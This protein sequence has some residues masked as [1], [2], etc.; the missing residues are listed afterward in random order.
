MS[1]LLSKEQIKQFIHD[2][3]IRI[4]N[5]FSV[6]TA[7]A[8]VDILWQ[9]LPCNKHDPTSWTAP[10]VRLGMYTHQ[11]FLD[12]VNS[13]DLYAAF[14]QLVGENKWL[15]CHSVGTFPVRFPS[16][17]PATDTGKHVDAS[18]PGTNAASYF[19]WRI[20]IRS[21]GR[22]L[23]MLV[24]FSDTTEADAPTIIYKGSHIDVAQLLYH[25]GDQGLS[26]ME[27]TAKLDSLPQRETALATGKAGTIYL[28][29]PFLVHA[30]SQH[31]GVA[32]R[33]MAQPPLLL[34]NE[35][36][37]NDSAAWYSPVEEAIRIAR[38]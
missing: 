38:P 15:P 27:L 19:D 8:A 2:G 12:A 33:F 37:I 3:F 28:C 7:E 29:H 16:K 35:L 30:A 6:Q 4:S 26:F 36:T 31:Q 14:D 17:E 9:D 18:F 32:P 24:L 25:E 20:N 21:K 11:P 34:R 5:A 23:L 13:P 10:V 22:A 1:D